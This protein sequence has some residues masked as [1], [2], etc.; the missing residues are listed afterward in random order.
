MFSIRSREIKPWRVAVLLVC[1]CV[2]VVSGLRIYV[3]LNQPRSWQLR[4]GMTA[5]EVRSIMGRPR[6][7]FGNPQQEDWWY[8]DEENIRLFF[9]DGRL[10]GASPAE[11][12]AHPVNYSR[13]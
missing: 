10:S 4:S 3:R 7:V 5:H 11:K 2:V 12:K 9:Y 1:M 8:S 6:V 13:G